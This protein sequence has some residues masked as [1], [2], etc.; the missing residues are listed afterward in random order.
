MTGL[1][2]SLAD[3]VDGGAYLDEPDLT[4]GYTMLR[5]FAVYLEDYAQLNR[6][7]WHALQENHQRLAPPDMHD[8]L[9]QAGLVLGQVVQAGRQVVLSA[10]AGD[11]PAG[12]AALAQMEQDIRTAAA[13]QA[14]LL[15]RAEARPGSAHD[16][17]TICQAL[18]KQAGALVLLGHDWV[19]GK[20]PGT[21]G[22]GYPVAYT[23]Y[24]T[25][26]NNKFSRPG[27]GLV[28]RYNQLAVA[29]PGLLP[30][31]TEPA[32]LMVIGPPPRSASARVA[33]AGARHIVLV[34]DISGSM[35]RRDK[36][37]LAQETL[38][39]WIPDLQ[40]DDR[41]SLLTF[42][43]TADVQAAGATS[44]DSIQ[45]VTQLVTLTAGGGSQGEAALA[46]ACEL[47]TRYYQPDGIN[48]IVLISDGG[49]EITPDL[50]MLTARAAD[51][52]IL[53]YVLYTGRD[54]THSRPHL[55]RLTSAGRGAFLHAQAGQALGCLREATE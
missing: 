32:W 44:A 45:L 3:Y 22:R 10:K 13:R 50:L 26:L 6:R 49:F 5:K 27:E 7:L 31:L 20:S 1:A 35:A 25:L 30:L 52:D 18:L 53:L 14:E 47:A 40:A 29:A 38:L 37:P 16:P 55:T 9:A 17:G 39:R 42:A 12:V 28:H 21:T 2:A 48:R 46:Q 34:L 24:N 43:E 54:L 33:G 8:P 51:R 36:L 11:I 4:S 19:A 41:V 15:A 23:Y